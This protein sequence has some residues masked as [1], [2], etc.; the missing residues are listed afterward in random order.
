MN[1]LALTLEGPWG[2]VNIPTWM[3]GLF[4]AFLCFVIGVAYRKRKPLPDAKYGTQ[5]EGNRAAPVSQAPRLPGGSEKRSQLVEMMGTEVARH[6]AAM[7]AGLALAKVNSRLLRDA[8]RDSLKRRVSDWSLGSL[9][10][11]IGRDP[12]LLSRNGGSDTEKQ[13]QTEALRSLL[14]KLAAKKDEKE[15]AWF[16][17]GYHIG[18]FSGSGGESLASQTSAESCKQSIRE[19]AHKLGREAEV[20]EFFRDPAKVPRPDASP[21]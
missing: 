10:K 14:R 7:E 6:G 17:L 15:A 20:E 1:W 11:D 21:A 19:S 3:I 13:E 2:V 9:G 5:R 16:D 8:Q 12:R 18:R 4:A